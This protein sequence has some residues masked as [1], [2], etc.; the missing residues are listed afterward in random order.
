MKTKKVLALLVLAVMLIS[1]MP[2]S[3]F[4]VNPSTSMNI[5]NSSV[6]SPEGQWPSQ[7]KPIK[8]DGDGAEFVITVVDVYSAYD[9][10]GGYDSIYIASNRPSVDFFY[11]SWGG[12]WH[13]LGGFMG[14]SDEQ[15][16]GNFNAGAVSGGVSVGNTA[17]NSALPAGLYTSGCTAIEIP[18]GRIVDGA[19]N[20]AGDPAPL[21][22]YVTSTSN[23]KN[24][25]IKVV[26]TAAGTSQIAVGIN[27]VTT[28]D[29]ARNRSLSNSATAGF[30]GV[31]DITDI[32][33][34]R[35]YPVEFTAAK[36]GSVTLFVLDGP[37]TLAW[38]N[39]GVGNADGVRKVVGATKPA[40]GVDSYSIRAYVSDGDKGNGIP[41]SG[42]E[43]TFYISSGAGA[44][45]SA[46]K[47]TTDAS[48]R[49]SVTIRSIRPDDIEILARVSGVT[50]QTDYTPNTLDVRTD[51]VILTFV[52]TGVVSLKAEDESNQKVA[53]DPGEWLELEV[54]AYDAAGNRFDFL[55]QIGPAGTRFD[56]GVGRV[57]TSPDDR[58]KIDLT[59]TVPVKPSGTNLIPDH[60]ELRV[61][62]AGNFYLAIPHDKMNRDGDFEIRVYLNN[63][64]TVSYAFSYRDQGDVTKIILDYGSDNYSAGSILPK[65]WVAYE[66]ADGYAIKKRYDK[67]PNRSSLALSISDASFMDSLIDTLTGQFM[68]KDDKSGTITMTVVDKDKNLVGTQ[69]LEIGKAASYLKLTPLSTGSV[70]GEVSVDIT[71]VDVDGKKAAT[72][73]K[74]NNA[75]SDAKAAIISKP[76][77]SVASVSSIYTVDFEDGI[78]NVK[79][80]CNMEGSVGLQVI[81]TEEWYTTTIRNAA[82][83]R[84][85]GRT[86]TGAC[87]VNFG[88]TVGGG[89]QL[90]F[91]IGAP[92]FVSGNTP[93]AAQSPA[94]IENDR[95]FLGIRDIGNAIGGTIEFDDET[96]TATV[97]KGNIVVKV[98]AGASVVLVTKNGVNSEVPLDVAAF[99][100]N[101]RIY[102]PFRAVLE[103]FGYNVEWNA[104][105]QAIICNI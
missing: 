11:V 14:S 4:G 104:E 38:A 8:N 26:S 90:I 27:P 49:A 47:A 81:I 99:I 96:Q 23:T 24:V 100:R 97:A 22:G 57:R 63:G 79:V 3:A 17:I 25:T 7:T 80:G 78:A 19:V 86:Y 37:T 32:I 92:S 84:Y 20:S 33:G 53:K 103:A 34:Q 9:A 87:T 12:S 85:G 50:E 82:G 43:V 77:G 67:W 88:T 44:T 30:P 68:L 98:T 65:P 61:N 42:K 71:L 10:V 29:Y 35:R 51:K 72:G 1:I 45:L 36:A 6:R 73:L 21:F 102:L 75:G 59:I 5:F 40:N 89:S 16:T 46:S 93:F 74:V 91:F 31:G 15:R 70:G 28:A 105:T 39:G 101:D 62:E 64:V 69:V 94:F 2:M 13:P 66:D 56:N 52:P 76:E 48:G 18:I 55:K 83:E 95:T 58:S 41:L 60:I 54:S